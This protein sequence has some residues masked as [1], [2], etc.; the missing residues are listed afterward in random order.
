MTRSVTIMSAAAAALVA[1]LGKTPQTLG[2][3]TAYVTGSKTLGVIVQVRARAPRGQAKVLQF[4]AFGM[5]QDKKGNHTLC[6]GAWQPTENEALRSLQVD[7]EQCN[8]PNMAYRISEDMIAQ[9][10]LSIPDAGR[11]LDYR[12]PPLFD[13]L[14]VA[15]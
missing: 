6:A 10:A 12:D 3:H 4:R 1:S 15:A 5:V 8:Q 9:G 13:D 11:V 14:P 7:F 2:E